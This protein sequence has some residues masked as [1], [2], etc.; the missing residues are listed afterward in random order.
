MLTDH[1]A[2]FRTDGSNDFASQTMGKRIPGIITETM[3]NNQDLFPRSRKALLELEKSIRNN[4]PL[5]E[6]DPPTP[7]W[8][9]WRDHARAHR[10][11][12]WLDSEWFYA[13]HLVYRLIIEAAGYWETG[14]DPFRYTKEDELVSGAPQ[15]IIERYM[16][17]FADRGG[18]E[19][20]VAAALHAS[21]WGNRIDLSYRVSSDLGSEAADGDL[22]I[23][24]DSSRASE[25]ILGGRGTG[26]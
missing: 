8:E 16:T 11:E 19:E 3:E 18:F 14:Y 12:R 25:I 7:D 9:R 6:L 10:G 21:L 1:P 23:D 5:L 2:P 20:A 24:D 22:L 13:E 17:A 15:G 4:S 26:R